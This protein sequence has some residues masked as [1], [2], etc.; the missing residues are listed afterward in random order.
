MRSFPVSSWLPPPTPI[1]Y[2]LPFEPIFTNPPLSVAE[3]IYTQA[4]IVAFVVPS[5]NT[6]AVVTRS[7]LPSKSTAAPIF[8]DVQVGPSVRVPVYPLPEISFAV[9][10]VFSSMFQ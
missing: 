2:P 10:P 7:S 3:S 5:P 1:E 9:V 6:E 8:P 4:P